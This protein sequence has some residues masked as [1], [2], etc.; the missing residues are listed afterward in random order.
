MTGL[1]ATDY[2][3]LAVRRVA[4]ARGTLAEHVV[5]AYTGLCLGCLRPGP[6]DDRRAALD[7]LARYGPPAARDEPSPTTVALT[8][9]RNDLDELRTACAA[10][11][12]AADRAGS[13]L[14]GTGRLGN[15]PA[16]F[17]R[18]VVDAWAALGAVY[19][20]LDAA[21][22]LPEAPSGN[23]GT[24][25]AGL[26]AARNDAAR[27]AASARVVRLR[28]TVAVDRLTRTQTPAGLVA[29]RRLDAAIVRLDLVA[30]RLAVGGRALDRYAAVLGHAGNP[31]RPKP[32]PVPVPPVGLPT[33]VRAGA[34]AAGRLV[35]TARRRRQPGF[36]SRVRHQLRLE[37]AR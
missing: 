5:S 33:D 36:W 7:D 26:R 3:E 10:I 25:L 16:S 6:C 1:P 15:H 34:F 11:V 21:R 13:V 8:A 30:A 22:K 9:V 32:E 2:H 14:H 18:A 37:A 28:L 31:G 23:V 24:M 19:A 29:A 27:A 35:A 17:P 12:T 4:E 20:G